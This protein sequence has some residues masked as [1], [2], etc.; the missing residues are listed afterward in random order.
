MENYVFLL[1][2][3]R[4][5]SSSAAFSWSNRESYLLELIVWFFEKSFLIEDSPLIPPYTTSLTL[6]EDLSLMWL[7][8]VHVTCPVISSVP[9]Y[10]TVST[11]HCP[12][13]FVLKMEHIHYI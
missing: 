13:Q 11:F 8:V 6:D 9:H 3:S 5:F 10:C 7:V 2:N 4:N 1:T 12:S